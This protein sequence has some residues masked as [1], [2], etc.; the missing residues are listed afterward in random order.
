MLMRAVRRVK[1]DIK[2]ETNQVAVRCPPVPRTTKVE[3]GTLSLQRATRCCHA[4]AEHWDHGLQAR[5]AQV[6]KEVKE[7]RERARW[8]MLLAI[9]KMRTRP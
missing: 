3:S 1:R 5:G 8:A 7:L 2:C 4:V 9:S 6:L